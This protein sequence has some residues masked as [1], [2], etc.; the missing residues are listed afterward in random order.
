ML[1][2]SSFAGG[3][4]RQHADQKQQIQRNLEIAPQGGVRYRGRARYRCGR[5]F[6]HRGRGHGWVQFN[7]RG[8]AAL[9]GPRE[10]VIW[11]NR[12]YARAFYARVRAEAAIFV[13][14]W[15]WAGGR[16]RRGA[17]CARRRPSASSVAEA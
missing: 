2:R 9:S 14:R 1:T 5:V 12:F 8:L 10:T 3:D 7:I 16:G 13:W 17:E 15:R 6:D 11:L 4:Q